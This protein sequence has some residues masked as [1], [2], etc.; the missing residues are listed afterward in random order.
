M[1]IDFSTEFQSNI[2]AFKVDAFDGTLVEEERGGTSE[3]N[4]SDGISVFLVEA[5]EVSVSPVPGQD[6]KA[7]QLLPDMGP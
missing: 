2:D 1:E 7:T 5:S 6:E 4:H 3:V